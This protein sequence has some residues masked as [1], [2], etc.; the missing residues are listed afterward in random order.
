MAKGG[1]IVLLNMTQ[2]DMGQWKCKSKEMDGEDGDWTVEYSLQLDG[3]NK[4]KGENI[5]AF[6][7]CCRGLR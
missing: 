2:G 7:H 1:G 6:Y 5:F 4:G 3:G